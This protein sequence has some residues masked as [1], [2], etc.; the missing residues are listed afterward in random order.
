MGDT[1]K[2]KIIARRY[3]KGLFELALESG[4]LE[5]LEADMTLIDST[6]KRVPKFIHA[7]ED[8]RISPAKRLAAAD[9][10]SRA[11]GLGDFARNAILLMLQRK[12]IAALDLV[13]RDVIARILSRRRLTRARANVADAS[14]A[15]DTKRRIEDILGKT[16]KLKVTC[17]VA[18]EPELIGGFVVRVGDMRYDAS[19]AGE[20]QRM[21]QRL[22]NA[23]T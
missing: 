16:L 18:V 4:E 12:R 7:L 21:R 20:L 13:A 11:L 3:A 15:N 6:A 10:I 22:L 17:E 23:E 8:E 2:E 5:Q 19:V 1:V 14:L 9:A